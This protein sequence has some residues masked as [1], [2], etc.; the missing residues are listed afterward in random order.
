VIRS[1]HPVSGLSH[2]KIFP[3]LILLAAAVVPG[4]ATVPVEAAAKPAGPWKT[5]PTRTLAD[6]PG[7]LATQTDTGL[8]AYGGLPSHTTKATGFFHPEKISDRWWLVDPDGGLFVHK[9]V[10]SVAPL[11]TPGAQ[12]AFQARFGD[13]S[14][15][16]A[17][18]TEWLRA[19]GFNGLGAWSDTARL[20]ATPTPLVYTS[21]WNF[22]ASYGRRRGG[23]FQ[24][25]GHTGY[26]KDCIF[27]FD[28]GFEK[29]C[30]EFAQQLAATKDDPWLL[31]HFS[32]NELPF[33]REALANYLSLPESDPGCAAATK[34]LRERHGAAATAKDITE[35]D[36]Q[37]FLALVVDRY[38]G[39][40]GRAIRKY[41]PHHLFLGPRI[42]GAAL[43]FPEVFRAAGPHLDVV[44]V[45]YYGAWTPAPERLAM[46]EQESGRP[47]LITEWYAKGMDSGLGNTTGAGWTVKTQADRGRF[48]EN[49][50]LGLLESK[51]CVG[52]HWFKYADND[53]TDP[54]ADPSNTDSNKGLVSNRYEPY[55]DL[56]AAMKRINERVYGLAGFF[57]SAAAKP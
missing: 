23:T 33:K 31:G 2:V 12:A 36:Q 8:D 56:V 9:G 30:D 24:Q 14:R 20:R 44:A 50:T 43:R 19:Q 38:L 16:A 54:G 3:F 46:W 51:V 49:F 22:M 40:V 47:C 27:V 17:Q 34:F 39:I 5:Y 35:R 26:P 48:Y 18:T 57:D 25:P 6:L 53:P 32:D 37:D 41:D 4:R 29:F 55:A 45:N 7:V 11:R 1:A 10:V 13:D 21:I 42:H 52:W 15:W 28:E